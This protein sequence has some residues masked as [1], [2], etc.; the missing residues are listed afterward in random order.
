[1]AVRDSARSAWQT[2]SRRAGSDANKLADHPVST[3]Q[4]RITSVDTDV[5]WPFG[6]SIPAQRAG[7]SLRES[8][9]DRV[10]PIGSR[11][12]SSQDNRTFE[13]RS[14]SPCVGFSPTHR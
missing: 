10:T 12:A 3:H 14:G 13:V 2:R 11:H 9:Q 4:L 8:S 1:M 5:R 6:T 7:Y